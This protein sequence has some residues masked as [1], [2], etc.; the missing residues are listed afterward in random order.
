T[1]SSLQLRQKT[2]I[3]GQSRLAA[4]V[5]DAIQ[6]R[7]EVGIRVLGYVGAESEP[8]AMNGLPRL[9]AVSELPEIVQQQ[10]VQRVIVAVGDRRGNLP[11]EE[12]LTLKKNGA[13][14]TEGLELYETITGKIPLESLRL[15]WLLFGRGFRISRGL[16]LYKRAFSILLGLPAFL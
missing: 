9:G 5:A 14:I 8:S 10:K 13:E 7:P 4:S 2:L 12:L 6:R 11:T 16:Q 1:V 3:L 15:S